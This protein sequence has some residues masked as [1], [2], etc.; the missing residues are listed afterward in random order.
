MTQPAGHHLAEFNFGTLAHDWEDPRVAGFVNGITQVNA[1]AERSP[2]F[3]WR[4]GDEEMGDVQEDSAGP[5]ADRPLTASTLSVW[6]TPADLWQFVEKTVHR[7]FM[8][9]AAEWFVPGDRGYFVAWW[10]PIGHRP[11]VTEGMQR[12]KQL[13]RDGESET[14][15]GTTGLLR[16]AT[17]GQEAAGLPE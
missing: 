5:L 14:V 3:V 8:A 11:T 15:F 7:R 13:D 16:R 17:G 1:I 6:E 10:V 2:G 9:R 4:L 12:W